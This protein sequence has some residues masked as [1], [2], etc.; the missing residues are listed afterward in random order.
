MVKYVDIHSFISV[1]VGLER[2]FEKNGLVIG[3]RPYRFDFR[4]LFPNRDIVY[5][6][7]IDVADVRGT[8][9][10]RVKRRRFEASSNILSELARNSENIS[11]LTGF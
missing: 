11:T 1:L 9:V 8:N 5:R 6:F 4:G 10:T 7:V 2:L 3:E